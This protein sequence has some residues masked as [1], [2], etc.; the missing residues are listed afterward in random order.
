MHLNLCNSFCIII[1]F[2]HVKGKVA[3]GTTDTAGMLLDMVLRKIYGFTH[4]GIVWSSLMA[5]INF[6]F[7]QLSN[8]RI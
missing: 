2:F 1:C 4:T 7:F 8:G 6:V 3:C 5:L